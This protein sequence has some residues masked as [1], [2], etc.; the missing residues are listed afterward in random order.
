MKVYNKNVETFDFTDVIRNQKKS[1]TNMPHR[2]VDK[3]RER[4]TGELSEIN[5]VAL[6]E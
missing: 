5:T 2:Y 3:R 6:S 1:L 4:E